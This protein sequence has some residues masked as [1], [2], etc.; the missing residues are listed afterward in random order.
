M[1][2][3]ERHLYDSDFTSPLPE[4][5]LAVFELTELR[6]TQMTPDAFERW[7]ELMVRHHSNPDRETSEGVPPFEL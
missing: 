2:D 7:R 1:H 4:T 3:D 6:R 5:P